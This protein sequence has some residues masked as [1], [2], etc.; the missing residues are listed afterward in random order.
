HVIDRF[1]AISKACS[2]CFTLR[3]SRTQIA[4]HGF[5]HE[6]K[7]GGSLPRRHQI[8]PEYRGKR[9]SIGKVEATQACDHDV[10]AHWI[11]IAPEHAGVAPALEQSAD[12]LEQRRAQLR[13]RRRTGEVTALMQV[14]RRL[15]NCAL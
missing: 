6:S 12:H 14:L 8:A 15:R 1:S 7:V 4:K 5:D 10:E 11:H 13:N 3:R 2:A 9:V